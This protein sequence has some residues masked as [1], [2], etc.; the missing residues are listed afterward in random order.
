MTTPIH[1]AEGA[2]RRAARLLLPHLH[3][4]DT[5]TRRLL[6]EAMV[7]AFGG[8][9]DQ[10]A[11]ASARGAIGHADWSAFS[12]CSR[13]SPGRTSCRG[14]SGHSTSHCGHGSV[15]PTHGG[16]C[17]CSPGADDFPSG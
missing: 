16:A 8:S 12:G 1:A 13:R 9:D 7:E 3:A 6:N 2:D 15:G 4:G 10:V 5:I 11:H 14:S 17:R